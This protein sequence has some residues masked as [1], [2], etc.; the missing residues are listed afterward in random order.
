MQAALKK[1]LGSTPGSSASVLLSFPADLLFSKQ[2][3]YDSNDRLEY[4]GYALPGTLTAQPRWC[5]KK[6]VYTNG[7]QTSEGFANG[8][9]FT[10]DNWSA[11]W[12]D[13]ASYSYS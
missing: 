1:I 3:A 13:R 6:M 9:G 7:C 10:D 12:D 2:L 4:L 8:I 11:T 5:I